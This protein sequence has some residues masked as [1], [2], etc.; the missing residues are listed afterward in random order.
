MSDNV[1][2][3]DH[4]SNYVYY[5]Y[6]ETDD[7]KCKHAV[8]DGEA[9]ILVPEKIIKQAEEAYWAEAADYE[10]SNYHEE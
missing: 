5:E 3:I 8:V 6:F 1:Y 9:V 10:L 4:P 2:R 7:L